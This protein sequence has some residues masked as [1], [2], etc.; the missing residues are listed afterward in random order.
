MSATV[1]L[2]PK[3][4]ELPTRAH[5]VEPLPGHR[6]VQVGPPLHGR[7]ADDHVAPLHR[8]PDLDR[9]AVPCPPRHGQWP[10]R[11]AA[12]P[13]APAP[14]RRLAGACASL[15]HT[16]VSSW[17]ARPKRGKIPAP[18]LGPGCPKLGPNPQCRCHRSCCSPPAVLPSAR[19]GRTA[20][21]E[22]GVLAF[23]AVPGTGH[24]VGCYSVSV[25][26]DASTSGLISGCRSPG[27][28][29]NDVLPSRDRLRAWV[30]ITS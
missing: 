26:M 5:N 25:M 9:V 7:R 30:V 13:I 12:A 15:A 8:V 4:S 14:E 22:D 27:F 28:S 24:V 17:W 6:D 23:A 3:Y 2:D 21:G 18:P 11:E 1:M 19:C 29:A 20:V 10:P 16:H